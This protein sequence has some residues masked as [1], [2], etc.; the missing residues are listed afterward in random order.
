M[1]RPGRRLLRAA[2]LLAGITALARVAGFARTTAFG[3]TVGSG[4]VGSIYQTANYI[5]NIVFDIVAG[6]MLSALVVP[7]LA[8]ALA[9][10]DRERAD[11]LLSALLNW[12]LVVLVP[13]ALIV[14]LAAGPIVSALL[15]PQSQC[16]GAHALGTRMLVVFA[17]QIVFYGLGIVLGGV[18][19]ASERFVWPAVAPLLSSLVVIGVYLAYGQLAGTGRDVRGLPRSAELVLSIGTTAGVVVLALS[20]IPPVLRSGARWR[21]T[22]RFPVE[23]AS[24]VRLAAAAGAATLAAQE[25]ST[26]VMIRL[27]N[28]GTARGTL[29]IVTM[30]QTLFLLPWAVLS[31]PIATTAFPRLSADWAAGS[32]PAYAAR[33]AAAGSVVIT[34]AAAGT[35]LLVAVAE[36][37]GI[38]LLGPRAS[39]LSAFAPTAVA[40]GLGLVGWSLVALLGRAL[41][42]SGHLI[43]SARAQVVGQLSVIAI[44]VG[45]SIVIP[46]SHRAFVLGLGNS[47]GVVIAAGLLM[48]NGHRAGAFAP[49]EWFGRSTLVALGSAAIAA[50][51]GALVGR[52]AHGHGTPVSVAWGLVAAVAAAVV[53]GALVL[54]LD[55]VGARA[56]LRR[57]RAAA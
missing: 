5:P 10:G 4:C 37:A 54:A 12:A 3:R 57:G 34:A 35:A 17:P 27:A 38:V 28:T 8:P 47:I 2:A 14:A 42:A 36:P 33:V 29:V 15:G 13:I 22:L 48:V 25:L 40:F 56:L 7:I 44:D 1:T 24:T 51:A 52:Q 32:R 31:L 50:V 41:Y 53:F 19:A 18:L 21:A 30:A 26:A 11:Q 43:A 55:P 49:R 39:A 9:A 46:S 45:L 23:V 20:L 6:G 16:G